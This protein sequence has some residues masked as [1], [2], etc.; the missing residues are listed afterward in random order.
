MPR[1]GIEIGTSNTR[2]NLAAD[3]ATQCIGT[4]FKHS[5]DNNVNIIPSGPAQIDG[6]GQGNNN[7]VWW[8][9]LACCS[10]P[11]TAQCAASC[12]DGSCPAAVH[13]WQRSVQPRVMMAPGLLQCT[14]DSAVCSLV[15]WWPLAC[16][17]ASSS[18][19]VMCCSVT[20]SVC[21]IKQAVSPGTATM[22]EIKCNKWLLMKINEAHVSM[23]AKRS[24]MHMHTNFFCRLSLKNVTL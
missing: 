22:S 7:L 15:W 3:A 23:N 21:S 19:A 4:F 8:W 2:S 6:C 20:A 18:D 10:A 13:L 24:T 9:P 5:I 17:S 16:C 1:P 14:Y 11:M 12:D